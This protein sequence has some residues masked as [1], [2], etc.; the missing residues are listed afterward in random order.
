MELTSKGVHLW[1]DQSDDETLDTL[2]FGVIGFDSEGIVRRYNQH[3][4]KCSSL[5]PSD[6]IGRSLF[7]DI[8]RC[9]NN[10]LIAGRFSQARQNTQALDATIDYV[11][12]F[13]SGAGPV[14]MRL[15]SS[16]EASLDYLL[17]RRLIS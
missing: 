10:S 14:H 9:M 5:A 12:A 8:A 1:L 17:I 13:K 3:E 11:L 6:V 16:P 7:I 15:L 2:D 4:A